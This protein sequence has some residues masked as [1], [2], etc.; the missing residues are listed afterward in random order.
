MSANGGDPTENLKLVMRAIGVWFRQLFFYHRDELKTLVGQLIAIVICTA[1]VT[2]AWA[3]GW[4]HRGIVWHT[5]RTLEMMIE[6]PAGPA[7]AAPL[8]LLLGLTSIFLFD[9]YKR[10]QGLLIFGAG[11]LTMITVA[12]FFDRLRLVMN[13][14]TIGVG[15]LMF[16]AGLFWGGVL[17]G[18]LSSGKAEMRK[19]F[20]RL[21]AVVGIFGVV[22][23]FEAVVDYDPP[24]IHTPNA[25]SVV[26]GIEVP[27]TFPPVAI[28]G[29]GQTLPTSPIAGIVY[30]VGLVGLLGALRE[31]TKYEMEKDVLILGPDRAG[32]TWLMSGAGFCL[33]NRAIANY[34]FDDPEINSSLWSYVDLFQEGKFDA[35]RL[36]AN[37]RDQFSFFSFKYEHGILPRRRLRVRTIDYAGEHLTDIDIQNP[38]ATFNSEWAEDDDKE[39]V[40]ANEVPDFETLIRLNERGDI[41]GDDI[42]SLLS[43]LIADYDTVALIL[44][45]DEFGTG[46]SDSRLPEHLSP[47]DLQGRITAR[48]T[49]TVNY[50]SVYKHLIKTYDA[51]DFFFLV[52]M[53]DVFLETYKQDRAHPHVDPKGTPNWDEFRKHIHRRITNDA[54]DLPFMTLNRKLVNEP[55][56]FYPVYFEAEAPPNHQMNGKFKP[57]LH[58][59]DDYYPLRGLQY[60]LK[61]M[62]R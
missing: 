39:G 14:P 19:G 38:W 12:L 25:S 62:G 1:I 20:Q 45:G 26:A 41:A 47:G 49:R 36:E 53:S 22:G 11:L 10:L 40:V 18:Q 6:G 46:L 17:E 60:L 31:F 32:K 7:F 33:H 57:N 56:H 55:T 2:A 42:P 44:P 51:T 13:F 28:D 35:N 54:T 37:E 27:A 30:L 8:G 5:M 16:V 59:D 61:R 29:F 48:Q 43:V 52:T 50:A 21:I 58:W 34:T 9:A 15:V 24:I 3:A 4:Q 23:I